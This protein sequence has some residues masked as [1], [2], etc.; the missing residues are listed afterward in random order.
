[1]RKVF[2]ISLTCRIY[3]G[4]ESNFKLLKARNINPSKISKHPYEDK[5]CDMRKEV[6]QGLLSKTPIET[7]MGLYLEHL[8]A[9]EIRTHPCF[10]A[11]EV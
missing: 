6:E 2:R 9:L 5:P 4:L 1:M 8:V 11:N 3:S 7:S 10:F